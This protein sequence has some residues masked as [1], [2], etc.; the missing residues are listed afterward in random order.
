M[1]QVA[2]TRFAKQMDP[3]PTP[4]IHNI[5]H[6]WRWNSCRLETTA[7]I[8]IF[9]RG[10]KIG[11]FFNHFYHHTV[12]F[13]ENNQW[14]EFNCGIFFWCVFTTSDFD[15]IIHFFLN[16]LFGGASASGS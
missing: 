10:G 8:G 16:F 12:S 6:Y 3:K 15:K 11:C 2:F 5:S 7:E 14:A 9:G 13:S 4:K 1:S